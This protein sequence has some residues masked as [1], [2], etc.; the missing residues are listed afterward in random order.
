[1]CDPYWVG[2]FLCVLI[3]SLSDLASFGFADMS[4]LAPLG[5]M[6]L[7]VSDSHSFNHLTSLFHQ[8]TD[9]I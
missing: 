6:T 8:L 2:G 3:G 9:I 1:M 5:A 4:L 7:V